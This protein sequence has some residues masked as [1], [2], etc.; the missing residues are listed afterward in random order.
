MNKVCYALSR[1]LVNK[2]TVTEQTKIKAYKAIYIPILTLR[3]KS[4]QNK[5]ETSVAKMKCLR[6]LGVTSKDRVKNDRI[7]EE[8]KLESIEECIKQIYLP[9]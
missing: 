8:L 9:W 7:R 3:C 5:S 6:M 1:R 2:K 4:K